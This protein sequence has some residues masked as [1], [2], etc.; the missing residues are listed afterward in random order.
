MSSSLLLSTAVLCAV[1]SLCGAR[2]IV[3]S[4]LGLSEVV[5]QPERTQIYIGSP[6]VLR[7]ANGDILTSADRFGSGFK[8]PRNVSVFRSSD[9]G[10]TWNMIAW[11]PNQYWSNLFE[12]NGTVYL[13]GTA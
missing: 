9:N 5:W 7:L 10:N 12:A 2:L 1:L 4:T 13:L 3:D 8:G 11:A 6:S